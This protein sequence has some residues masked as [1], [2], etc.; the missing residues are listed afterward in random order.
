MINSQIINRIVRQYIDGE[1]DGAAAV[2]QMN[3]ELGA[4]D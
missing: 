1:L 4:I 3:E 2:A